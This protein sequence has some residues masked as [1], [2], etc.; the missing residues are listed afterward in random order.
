MTRNGIKEI[1]KKATDF[2]I[3]W[4]KRKLGMTVMVTQLPAPS[5]M[6][7]TSLSLRPTTF[8]PLTSRRLWSVSRPLRAADES[9]TKLTTSPFFKAKPTW[10]KLSLCSVIVRSNGLFAIF[11][12]KS[13]SFTPIGGTLSSVKVLLLFGALNKSRIS[14]E[15]NRWPASNPWQ[16]S[17]FHAFHL[18]P[19]LSHDDI[20]LRQIGRLGTRFPNYCAS[21]FLITLSSFVRSQG[22]PLPSHSDQSWYQSSYRE[23]FNIFFPN[24]DL[25]FI[26][27][28]VDART[29]GMTLEI[30]LYHY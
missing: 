26:Q 23:C 10:P 16:T 7:M 11:K 9:L 12:E 27:I 13:S 19:M 6:R 14:T 20:N 30:L 24:F 18:F 25:F 21:I 17:Q 28:L 1:F 8:W 15:G 5:M 29:G 3:M 2:L 22:F 4:S